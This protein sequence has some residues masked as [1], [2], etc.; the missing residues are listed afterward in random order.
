MDSPAII[1]A[2]EI[3]VPGVRA[4]AVPAIDQPT[5]RVGAESLIAVCT[6]LR[7]APELRFTALI[8]IV[9]VDMLPRVPR[10]ELNYCLVAT[11]VPARLR[12]KVQVD[13]GAPRIPSVVGVWPAAGFLEREVWD[14]LG[15]TFDGHPDLRRLLMPEDWTGHPL[16]KD[17]PVQIDAPVKVHAPLQLTEEQFRANIANDR[18]VRKGDA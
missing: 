12:V 3:L 4:E 6:A 17:Y 10:F 13:G 7:D 2:L 1:A 11:S 18:Q 16:R 5:V 14:L 15:V 9:G 8:D